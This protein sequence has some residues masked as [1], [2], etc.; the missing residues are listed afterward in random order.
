MN[1]KT[2]RTRRPQGRVQV[3]RLLIMINWAKGGNNGA[4]VGLFASIENKLRAANPTGI[5]L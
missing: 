4:A 2:E 1:E 3:V 5:F